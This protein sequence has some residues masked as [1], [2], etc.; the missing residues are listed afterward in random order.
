MK[1]NNRLF[2]TETL[3]T[4]SESSF[5]QRLRDLPKYLPG[6]NIKTEVSQVSIAIIIL[7]SV[8]FYLLFLV[9]LHY[10]SEKLRINM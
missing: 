6:T 2:S 8:Q 1:A 9:P 7:V 10:L 3:A 4:D 5:A